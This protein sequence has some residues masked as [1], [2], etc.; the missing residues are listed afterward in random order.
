MAVL[1]R[2]HAAREPGA[3]DDAVAARR[4]GFDDVRGVGAQQVMFHSVRDEVDAARREQVTDVDRAPGGH[5]TQADVARPA[6][7]DGPLECRGDLDARGD[8]VVTFDEPQ[9]DVL[10]AKTL[11]RRIERGHE[12]G[13][14]G[15][16]AR[17]E[18]ERSVTAVARDELVL[19]APAAFEGLTQPHLGGARVDVVRLE[20]VPAGSEVG[21]RHLLRALRRHAAGPPGHAEHERADTRPAAVEHARRHPRRRVTDVANHHHNHPDFLNARHSSTPIVAST[22]II[23]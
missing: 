13:A 15:V 12:A 6:R 4:G 19:L 21:A 16:R 9:V 8:A 7:R 23:R 11:Q 14:G 5:V 22:A 2:Q 17:G 18:G 20:R 3:R 10:R 1:A